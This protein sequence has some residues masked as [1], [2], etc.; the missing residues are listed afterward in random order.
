M[1]TARY[2]NILGTLRSWRTNF[3]VNPDAPEKE[4]RK[5][6]ARAARKADRR[7]DAA[8]TTGDDVLL[9]RARK[10]AKRARYAA[11]LLGKGRNAKRYK[12]I[13]SVLGDHQDTVVATATLRKMALT[14]GTTQ[15][16]N[17]FTFGL[18]YA[19]EQHLAAECRR[20]AGR[21]V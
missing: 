12:R 18:L 5:S 6:A 21:L 20:A 16:E 4:V 13:Q 17:G 19:R 3:P 2:R 10:A 9:H 14:A 1:E 15:G 8:L 7:L 11:E